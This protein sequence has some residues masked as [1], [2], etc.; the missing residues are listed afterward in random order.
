MR[1]R[2]VL[3]YSALLGLGAASTT[4]LGSCSNQTGSS[5][6]GET[7][8]Q[9]KT[10]LKAALLPWIGWGSAH[11]AEKK[12]FFTEEGIEVQQTVFQTVTEINTSLLAKQMDLGWLVAVDLIVLSEK[13][14]DL[15][16]IY[17]CDYSGDVDA[18]VGH[19]VNSAADL[20]GKKFAREDVPYEIVFTG[21]FLETAGL[22]EK[23]LQIQSLLTPDATAA[24]VAG[25]V[26]AVATYE[27]F[28]SKALKERPGSKILKT[29]KG[30][31]II[32]NGLASSGA[33]LQTRREDVLAYLR[34][35][36]KGL[37]FSQDNPQE[38]NELIAKWV[39]I[40]PAEVADQLTRIK[41]MDMAANRA[42]AFNPSDP[43]S[44]M[45]SIDSAA[46]ILIKAGKVDKAVP[47]KDLV[48]GSLVKAL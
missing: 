18:I 26:D 7:S 21:R 42:V 6:P 22:T 29:P 3:R 12:G 39:G 13:A 2:E 34:A 27:P 45:Q 41:L 31:N 46:P 14:P 38:A 33:L 32:I 23:D 19:G 35:I 15:K 44:V 43:L 30:T 17:A 48:D 10:P 37:K 16:F 28:V 5:P 25:K 4:V 24:F 8:S 40:T 47:G 9:D 20:K 11:I 36:A 1:R